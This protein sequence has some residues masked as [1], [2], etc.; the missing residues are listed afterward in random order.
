MGTILQ[1]RHWHGVAGRPATQ[2]PRCKTQGRCHTGTAAY[3]HAH[4]DAALASHRWQRGGQA[5]SLLS[6]ATHSDADRATGVASRR[7]THVSRNADVRERFGF[8]VTLKRTL[9]CQKKQSVH[10]SKPL[11]VIIILLSPLR[12]GEQ[13]NYKT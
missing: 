7:S 5:V 11:V 6:A 8:V 2:V 10:L 3:V 4:A 9:I 1:C 12:Y 13:H